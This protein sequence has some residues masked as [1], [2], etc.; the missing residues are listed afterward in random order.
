MIQLTRPEKEIISISGRETILKRA[1]EEFKNKAIEAHVFGSV[2][3][4]DADPYSD[5]DIWFTFEDSSFSEI[6]ENRFEYYNT[7]GKIIHA[8]EA[9][10]NAPIGGVHTA[11]IIEIEPGYLTMVDIYLCPLSTAYITDEAKKLF[12]IDLPQGT[13]GFNPQKIQIDENYRIDFFICFIFNTI[14]KIIRKSENPL[15]GVI[16]EYN[17]LQHNYGIPVKTLTSET[18]HVATL[19][20]IIQN[21]QIIA[22]E[23]QKM[24]LDKILDFSGNL[25][26]RI[27]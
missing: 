12:G 13:I 27:N 14:K 24:T 22:N 19:E 9:P 16:R 6:Y 10:Q 15:D 5:L 7:N 2:A 26:S 25:I 8:C 23:K 3:R 20:E 1:V 18:H 11:L 17:N 21:T 4:N